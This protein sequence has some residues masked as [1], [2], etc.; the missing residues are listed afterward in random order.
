MQVD[1][2]PA[3]YLAQ[4]I[5]SPSTPKRLVPYYQQFNNFYEH[6]LWYQL[7]TTIELFLHDEASG[8]FQIDLYHNFIHDFASKLNQ[9]KLASIAISV[10]RQ[11]TDGNQ[12]LEFLTKLTT[13]LDTPK[14]KEAFVLATMESAHFK[15]LLGDNEGTKEAMD[16]C[17]KVLDQLD[18]VDLVV[19]ASFY[20]VSGDYY[21]AKAEY[22]DYYKSSLLYLACVNIDKDLQ[23]QE[24]VQRAHDLGLSALL[25]K[26]YNFGELLMH[27]ILESLVST[28]HSWIRELLF[29]FNAGD[30]S[31]FDAL[32][33][34]LSQE[35]IL[36]ESSGFLRQKI[37]LMALIEAVF[38][39]PT[40][41]R[42]LPF[43]IIAAET[44]V[45]VDEVEILIM[46]SLSLKLIRGTIDQVNS[47]V[48]VNWV[49]PRVLD[50][51]Q[52]DDLRKR[53]GDWSDRVSLVGDLAQAQGGP[54]LFV[55]G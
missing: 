27:P 44:R 22:A 15:L 23:S 43:S 11:Y 35:P 3:T 10:A 7:T 46:K 33:P 54:E 2:E 37:C 8:P 21:K 47:T 16:K 1:I 18:S 28:P 38:K 55:Q 17:E 26:I 13:Q 45:P 36:Q 14:T 42:V 52:I 24:R 12:A 40:T 9:L 34:A 30:I 53:L 49:Q 50:R 6:R 32:L 41:D 31:K 51:M 29:A 48:S 20:R 19:H 4:A 39:R 5:S 25:G